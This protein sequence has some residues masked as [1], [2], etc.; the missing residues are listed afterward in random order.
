M[1]LRIRLNALP[2]FFG[3]GRVTGKPETNGVLFWKS[4]TVPKS[5]AV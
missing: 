5:L 4:Y 2:R 3:E 1:R